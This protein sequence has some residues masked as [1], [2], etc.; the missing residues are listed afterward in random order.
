MSVRVRAVRKPRRPGD[1][2][3]THANIEK[4]RRILGYDPTT[5]L[6]AGLEKEVAWFRE[7]IV[8]KLLNA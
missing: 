3:K 4:A 2:L 6:R 7:K 1:Q 8:G 5:T